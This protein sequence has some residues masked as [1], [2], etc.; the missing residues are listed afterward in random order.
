MLST[1]ELV[2]EQVGQLSCLHKN[3]QCILGQNVLE[4]YFDRY[5]QNCLYFEIIC[6]SAILQQMHF[7]CSAQ[8]R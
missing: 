3:L 2:I 4:H 5:I 1:K 6:T 8:L 7:P